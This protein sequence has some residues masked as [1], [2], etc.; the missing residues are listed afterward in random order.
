MKA[1]STYKISVDFW[2]SLV[3]STDGYI[4][5]GFYNDQGASVLLLNVMD[6]LMELNEKKL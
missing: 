5:W 3:D 2:K 1:V 4:T 6:P